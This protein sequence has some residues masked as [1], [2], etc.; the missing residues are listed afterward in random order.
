[1]SE[2]P[3]FPFCS[4]KCKTIDLGRWLSDRYSIPAE[5]VDEEEIPEDLEHP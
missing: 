1:M 3:R 2:W 4:D 5:E